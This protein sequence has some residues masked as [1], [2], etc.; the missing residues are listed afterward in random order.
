MAPTFPLIS[1]SSC[2][3]PLGIVR[4]TP[5]TIAITVIFLVLLTH[6][7]FFQFYSETRRDGKVYYSAGLL[8]CWLIIIIIIIVFI[9]ISSNFHWRLALSVQK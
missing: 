2:S 6:F 4:Y 9:E 3:D 5:T 1:K 7:A 8:F